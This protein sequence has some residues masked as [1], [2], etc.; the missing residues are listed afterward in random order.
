MNAPRTRVIGDL[1]A[2]IR[3]PLLRLQRGVASAPDLPAETLGDDC[4]VDDTMVGQGYGIPKDAP[5]R[6]GAGSAR[7]TIVTCHWYAAK[8]M[9]GPPG[10]GPVQTTGQR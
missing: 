8:A 1:A 5:R 9:A 3:S 6:K 4:G 10:A 2:G 7:E